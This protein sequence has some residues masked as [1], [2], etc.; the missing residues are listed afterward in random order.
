MLSIRNEVIAMTDPLHHDHDDDRS[1]T[2]NDFGDDARDTF[3]RAK[4]KVKDF[5]KDVRNEI[6]KATD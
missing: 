1:Y 2:H 5:G 4:E 3:D 6:D